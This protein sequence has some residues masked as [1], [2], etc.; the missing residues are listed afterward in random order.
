M[1][2]WHRAELDRRLD[3]PSPAPS[4]PWEEVVERLRRQE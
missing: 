2:D 3:N 4:L 1:P